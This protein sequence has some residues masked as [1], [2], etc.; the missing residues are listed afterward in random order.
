MFLIS[1]DSWQIK[2]T[3]DKG[4]GVFARKKIWAGTVIGDYLGT[5]I[6]IAEYDIENDNKG[7][8]L[9]RYNDHAGIYPDLNKPGIH[10]F[11]HS[12]VPNCWVY[13]HLGHTLFF[14]LRYISPGEEFTISYLLSPKDE[15][16][17][18]CTHDCRCGNACCLGTMHLPKDTYEQWQR[19]QDTQEKK[20]K[21]APYVLNEQLPKLSSYPLTIPI[22]PFYEEMCGWPAHRLETGV[23]R[24]DL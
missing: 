12:C 17:S 9:M 11:N 6:H 10:F 1:D 4:L 18:P 16:C 14:A 7:L 5:V 3:K 21:T 23:E 24:A 15:T 2:R 19:F 8:F 22:N 20:I 13:A